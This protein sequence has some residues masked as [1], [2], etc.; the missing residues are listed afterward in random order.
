MSLD[1][2]F[3]KLSGVA[4]GILLFLL[5]VASLSLFAV[6]MESM[7]KNNS[8]DKGEG[9]EL[10]TLEPSAT[11]VANGEGTS[12][13][14]AQT[15][16]PSNQVDNDT[17][18]SSDTKQVNASSIPD[19]TLPPPP[20]PP[21]AYS[22]HSSSDPEAKATT[23]RAF[24]GPS[25][26]SQPEISKE[27]RN[28]LQATLLSLLHL[29]IIIVMPFL[30]IRGLYC[31]RTPPAPDAFGEFLL[32]LLY[33]L[34]VLGFIGGLSCWFEKL[35]D[36]WPEGRRPAWAAPTT[37]W[38]VVVFPIG[39]L[40][41]VA[42]PCWKWALTRVEGFKEARRLDEEGGVVRG[43]TDGGRGEARGGYE[44]VPDEEVV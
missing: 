34:Q 36:L 26:T 7:K 14:A 38:L 4:A 20:S 23:P 5:N 42:M 17:A 19:A 15:D 39:I 10:A 8:K 37:A 27:S 32:W 18:T 33:S 44:R 30:V 43:N 28:F 41:A 35:G 25:D 21:P 22:S 29:G 2:D 12:Q 1:A 11:P 16:N 6:A 40:G 24:D 3:A 9:Q 31:P 13:V